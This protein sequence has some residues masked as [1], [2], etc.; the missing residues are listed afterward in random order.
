MDFV[1]ALRRLVEYSNPSSKFE[2]A[3][4]CISNNELLLDNKALII[5]SCEG[6]CEIVLTFAHPNY[7]YMHIIKTPVMVPIRYLND[8]TWKYFTTWKDVEKASNK[9]KK[10][11][12]TELKNILQ[13]A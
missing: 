10:D 11:L 9:A 8:K 4:F 6:L 13:E 5:E 2:D 12:E 7:S 3:F 1:E